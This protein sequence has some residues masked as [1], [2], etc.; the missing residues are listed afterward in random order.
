[1]KVYEMWLIDA[2]PEFY[3]TSEKAF[4]ALMEVLDNSSQGISDEDIQQMKEE[5]RKSYEEDN[6]FYG[7]E[8]FG[9]VMT[10]EVY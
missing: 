6:E 2:I 8:D 10:H 7:I 4:N 9:G 1:M 5:L 3:S